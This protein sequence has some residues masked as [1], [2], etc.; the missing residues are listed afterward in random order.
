MIDFPNA[1]TT[2]QIFD[3]WTWN[4]T[5]WKLTAGSKSGAGFTF[6]QDAVPTA[7]KAGDTWYQTSTGDSFLWVDD[8]S[9]TQWVQFAPGRKFNAGQLSFTPTVSPG[10]YVPSISATTVQAAVDEVASDTAAT[11]AR[12]VEIMGTVNLLS[13]TAVGAG[14]TITVASISSFTPRVGR[15]YRLFFRIRAITGSGYC[16]LRCQGSN[17]IATNDIYAFIGGAYIH[18]D[19]EIIFDGNGASSTYQIVFYASAACTIYSGDQPVSKFYIEDVG[20]AR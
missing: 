9:S 15:R 20:P 10:P 2:G 17:N 13:G 18:H 3:K 6:I 19:I 7:T 8:G 5:F 1:P 12:G 4:G 11:Y 14:A 16:Y